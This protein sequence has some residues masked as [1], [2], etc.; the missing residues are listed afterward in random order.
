[1]KRLGFS[2]SEHS[3]RTACCGASHSVA[4]ADKCENLIS[5]IINEIRNKNGQV[6][7]TICPLCQFNLDAAQRNTANPLPVPYFT[8]LAGL[9]IGIDPKELGISKLLVPFKKD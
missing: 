9:A 8:Q 4:Y 5:R 2:V 3:A 6:I 1:M 7:T